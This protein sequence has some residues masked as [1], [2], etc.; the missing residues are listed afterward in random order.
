MFNIEN[1]EY[2]NVPFDHWIID[3]FLDIEGGKK[4][5]DEFIDYD[6][7][8]VVRYS[9]WIGEKRTCNMWNR[10]PPLTYKT[11]SNLLS[12]AK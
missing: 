4:L 9:G 12:L 5:S 10:F 2:D 1:I 8:D 3:D 7:E 11:F 6:N